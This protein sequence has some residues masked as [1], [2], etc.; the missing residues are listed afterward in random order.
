MASTIMR[1]TSR[2]DRNLA[3]LSV[4]AMLCAAGCASNIGQHDRSGPD[5]RPDGA[6]LIELEDGEGSAIDVVTYPGGD[7]VD[8]KKVELPEDF[9]G[10]LQVRLLFN[11]PRDGLEISFEVYDARFERVAVANPPPGSG[12][13]VLEAEV[14]PA[15]GGT[16]YFHIFAP[17]RADAAEYMLAVR[18]QRQDVSA[19]VDDDAAL[20]RIPD[21]PT[22]PAIAAGDDEPQV[23]QQGGGA[24][25]QQ[26]GGGAQGQQQPPGGGGSPP[27]PDPIQE[28]DTSTAL[29]PVRARVVT[30]QL[31]SDGAV[32]LTVNRGTNDGVERGWTGQMMMG[33]SGRPLRGGTF[34]VTRV[35]SG[36]AVGQARVSVDQIRANREVVL[37]PPGY[38]A[39]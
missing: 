17:T 36:E 2:R 16:Y 4:A 12:A 11:P 31:G 27:P 1:S 15:F 39:N 8:W 9:A 20:P 19:L 18:K 22:L 35:T 25:G 24:Q 26:Q 30:Y 14:K 21:P 34:T 38:E 32:I 10:V 29:E 5:Y 7:R 3:S 33:N 28:E 37:M 13:R 23:A 6:M